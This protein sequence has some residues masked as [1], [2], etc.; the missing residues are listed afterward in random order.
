MAETRNAVKELLGQCLDFY[1]LQLEDTKKSL[2]LTWRDGRYGVGQLFEFHSL[3]KRFRGVTNDMS[4]NEHVQACFPGCEGIGSPAQID[5]K[6]ANCGLAAEKLRHRGW[7]FNRMCRVMK[8]WPGGADAE[9]FLAGKER[10]KEYSDNE[11]L[12]MERWASKFYC[13]SF[14]E[15]FGCPP[16]LPHHVDPF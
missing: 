7:Y 1:G 9:T 11:L 10:L 14:H 2:V 6:K 13:Q 8:N 3:N 12:A 4:F 16:I 5:S 15:K